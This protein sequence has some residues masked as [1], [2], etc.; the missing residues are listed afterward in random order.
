MGILSGREIERLVNANREALARGDV[1]PVPSI[2]ID[3]FDPQWC[4]PNSYDVHLSP[5]LRVYALRTLA[6]A[7]PGE[8]QLSPDRLYVAFNSRWIPLAEEID[9]HEDNPTLPLTIPESGLLLQPGVLYLGATVERTVCH[10]LVPW[11]DG[12]SSVGRLGLSAHV[13]AGRGDDGWPGRWTL[14]MT[15][16]HPLR[17]YPLMRVGQITYFTLDGERK[18][19]TGRYA[20]QDGPTSSRYWQDYHKK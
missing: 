14:E 15:V 20:E 11:L 16:V 3:P 1:P 6:D 12:R 2:F 17:V 10:G 5:E 19:Y 4:G 8:F 18:P 13:T 9:A 7:H